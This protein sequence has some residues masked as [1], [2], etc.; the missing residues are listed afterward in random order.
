MAQACLPCRPYTCTHFKW[1]LVLSLT[2]SYSCVLSLEVLYSSR[3]LLL[4]LLLLSPA[5]HCRCCLCGRLCCLSVQVITATQM[6]ESMTSNPLPTRA[7]MTD[8]A[9]AV[10]DG[11]G[12]AH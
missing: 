4:L 5:C 8:V 9:N 6:L 12:A 1:Q 11:T 3:L 10:F 7:E 2:A